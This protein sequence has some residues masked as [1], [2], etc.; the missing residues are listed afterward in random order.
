MLSAVPVQEPEQP[1]LADGPRG[2]R[3]RGAHVSYEEVSQDFSVSGDSDGELQPPG[4][5]QRLAHAQVCFCGARCSA[6]AP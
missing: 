2:L 6:L 4:K 3:V 5:R 1:E